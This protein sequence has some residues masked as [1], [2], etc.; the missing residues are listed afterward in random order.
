MCV[1]GPLLRSWV[2]A[3]AVALLSG[4]PAHAEGSLGLDEVLEAVKSDP[5]LVAEIEAELKTVGL[6]AAD[7]VCIGARHGNHWKHLGGGRAAPYECEIGKR[8]IRIEADRIYFDDRGKPLGNL[9][10][11]ANKRQFSRAVTFRESHFRWT[12][13][14]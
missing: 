1:T 9:E 11:V 3:A 7:V 14:P 4:L 6:K 2:A 13:K 12:W 10:Q 8:E 5:R